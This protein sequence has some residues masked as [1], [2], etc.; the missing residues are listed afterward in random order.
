M[1]GAVEVVLDV[2]LPLPLLL[3]HHCIV[4]SVVVQQLVTGLKGP[5]IV[6]TTLFMANEKSDD[7]PYGSNNGMAAVIV[8][9]NVGVAAVVDQGKRSIRSCADFILRGQH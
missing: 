7:L 2:Q 9:H 8:S 5:V 6:V 1:A 4:V 3:R